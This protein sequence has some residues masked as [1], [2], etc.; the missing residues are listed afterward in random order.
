MFE[1]FR[2]RTVIRSPAEV[3]VFLAPTNTNLSHSLCPEALFVFD[4]LPNGVIDVTHVCLER[5]EYPILT[6]SP[7]FSLR[8]AVVTKAAGSAFLLLSFLFG[9]TSETLEDLPFGMNFMATTW[10]FEN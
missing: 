7:S 9:V 3:R 5:V 2:A 1:P 10:A 4:V 6:P 8:A